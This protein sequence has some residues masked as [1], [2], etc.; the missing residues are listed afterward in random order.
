MSGLDKFIEMLHENIK[1]GKPYEALMQ[2]KSV[3]NRLVRRTFDNALQIIED[4]VEQ[5]SQMNDLNAYY[6]LL[7]FYLTKKMEMN[8]KNAH[9]FESLL[10]QE[11]SK[12]KSKIEE[13]VISLIPMQMIEV[14]NKFIKDLGMTH[15]KNG[16]YVVALDFF[17][18]D[19][20][21]LLEL[22][23]YAKNDDKVNMKHLYLVA[24][25]K[26]VFN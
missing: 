9:P 20:E 19:K 6:G 11:A 12:D 7:D 16:S 4:G 15:M 5:F 18:D 24:T 10:T 14:R 25:I 2:Y 26:F 22:F 1:E 3:F 21:S 23:N 17:I 8:E 13:R